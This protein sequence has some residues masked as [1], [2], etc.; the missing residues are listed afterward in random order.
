MTAS[1]TLAEL[2]ELARE[3][4]HLHTPIT[5]KQ[6]KAS[7]HAQLENHGVFED[8]EEEHVGSSTLASSTL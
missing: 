5:L 6:S 3:Y 4:N 2:Q 1:Y 7:L 8:G